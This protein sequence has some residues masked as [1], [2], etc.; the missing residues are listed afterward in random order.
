M[1]PR[2]WQ[3]VFPLIDGDYEYTT[4]ISLKRTYEGVGQW[5][6]ITDISNS[7]KLGRVLKERND[8]LPRLP[9][10]F[11]ESSQKELID[12]LMLEINGLTLDEL[13]H[14]ENDKVGVR[15]TQNDVRWHLLPVDEKEGY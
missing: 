12:T 15:A 4:L 8:R 13:D 14:Y 7:D 5:S 9:I 3:R 6:V 2:E 1:L 10:D 11:E